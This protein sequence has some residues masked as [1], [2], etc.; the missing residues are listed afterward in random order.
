MCVWLWVAVRVVV[1]EMRK[2]MAVGGLCVEVVEV[3][4][5]RKVMAICG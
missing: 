3:G 1:G 2:V 4:E 5:M